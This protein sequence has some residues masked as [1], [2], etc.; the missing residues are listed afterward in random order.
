MYYQQIQFVFKWMPLLRSLSLG[1]ING[2]DDITKGN[3]LCGRLHPF[4]LEL[5]EGKYVRRPIRSSVF[6]IQLPDALIVHKD[7]TYFGRFVELLNQQRLP[8][9]LYQPFSIH[10]SRLAI[11]Y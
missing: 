10:R 7:N 4:A 11:P 3:S 5:A 1:C 2:D 9:G 6:S 8:C